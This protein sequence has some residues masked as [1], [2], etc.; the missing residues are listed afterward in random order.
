M[1]RSF[2]YVENITFDFFKSLKT[3]FTF[4]YLQ[5]RLTTKSFSRN[6]LMFSDPEE[7]QNSTFLDAVMLSQIKSLALHKKKPT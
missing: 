2:S 4:L 5:R 7:E 6:L 1:I 3:L